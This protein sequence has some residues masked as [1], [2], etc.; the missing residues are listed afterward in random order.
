MLSMLIFSQFEGINFIIPPENCKGVKSA[1]E[2]A[3]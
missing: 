1:L 2:S 3:D